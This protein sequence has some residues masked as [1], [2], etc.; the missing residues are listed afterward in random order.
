MKTM[1]E[2]YNEVMGSDELKKEF[3]AAAGSNES[4]Q[5]FL[6]KYD[7]DATV[8]EVTAFLK[9][10]GGSTELSDEDIA[11]VAG[12]KGIDLDDLTMTTAKVVGDIIS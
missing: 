3:L 2:L 10:K 6:K 1:E 12:G 11:D 8:E 9:T 4:V 7:C 5:A